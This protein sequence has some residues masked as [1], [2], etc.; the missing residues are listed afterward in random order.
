M[1]MIK[2]SMKSKFVSEDI[3]DFLNE[4]QFLKD[5]PKT[6]KTQKRQRTDTVEEISSIIGQK[7]TSSKNKKI[8]SNFEVCRETREKLFDV[9]S[10]QL[11]SRK[12]TNDNLLKSLSEVLTSLEADY[13]ALKDNEQKLENLTGAFM[14]CIQQ[15]TSAHKQKLKALKEI[16]ASFQK[17]CQEMEKDH[18]AETDR[19]GSE[20][21]ED[22]KKLQQKL[23]SETKR[24]GW[25]NLRRTIFQA[26]QNDF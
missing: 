8:A 20:L 14:K 1:S 11:E 17:E 26:M 22:I 7:P 10:G 5:S 23:I 19:L 6:K 13:N 2:K 9:M 24:S 12:R 16:H 25:E 3:S 4:S 15:A 18:K 21:E